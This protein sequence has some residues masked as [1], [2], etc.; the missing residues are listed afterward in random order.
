M[1][2]KTYHMR[3]D[4]SVVDEL[5]N[6]ISSP[7][8]GGMIDKMSPDPI[9]DQQ[10]IHR[11]DAPLKGL[12]G[13][14]F[15]L[16]APF[17]VPEFGLPAKI[18]S[19]LGKLAPAAERIA[20]TLARS[21]LA[22]GIGAANAAV[23]G[24]DPMDAALTQGPLQ[25]AGEFGAATLPRLGTKMGLFSGGGYL[26][27]N[28]KL[29]D[30]A[31]DAFMAEREL[32]GSPLIPTTVGQQGRIGGQISRWNDKL[33]SVLDH[34]RGTTSV[35]EMRGTTDHLYSP[36]TRRPQDR[37][38]NIAQDEGDFINQ[39]NHARGGGQLIGGSP[40]IPASSIVD[41][42]GQPLRAAIPA[43]PPTVTAPNDLSMR[44]L[45]D[46]LLDLTHGKAAKSVMNAEK[47]GMYVPPSDAEQAQFDKVRGTAL[48]QL[49]NR[50]E[51]GAILPDQH[52][53]NLHPMMEASQSMRGGGS[54]MGDWRM[55][56]G[57]SAIGEFGGHF[58][59]LPPGVGSALGLATLSPV[60]LALEGELGGRMAQA[61]PSIYNLRNLVNDLQA[62]HERELERQAAMNGA[63][64]QL[65]KP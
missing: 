31:I 36:N 7:H 5:G 11:F 65:R 58:A 4:G 46:T 37:D 51:E 57:R 60:S 3:A 1:P 22:S 39:Q 24:E 49:R 32:P 16:A 54:V 13:D 8:D 18:T 62:E 52:L 42:S 34:S 20:P 41:S 43:V 9:K 27:Q 45:Q 14:T 33:G 2:Q 26:G 61:A 64:V 56:L 38:L 23:K 47:A 55:M 50:K 35:D 21:G 15:Q 59:G 29:M 28:R 12:V 25:A 17:L 19:L 53:A 44:D 40:A 63:P 10:G 6:T 48:K 30:K